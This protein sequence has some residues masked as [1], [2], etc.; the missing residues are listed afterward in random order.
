ML[1]PSLLSALR[2]AT[3]KSIEIDPTTIALIPTS[4]AKGQGGIV[5]TTVQPPREPQTFTIESIGA[6]LQGISGT[7][8]G[9]VKTE[10]G[11]AKSWSFNL[12]GRHDCVMEI[13][14]HWYEG[15]TGYRVISVQPSNGYEKR[16]V[17]AAFGSDPKYGA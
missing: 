7:G 3:I 2:K 11:Q 14:D 10:G 8:G 5:T 6:T 9:E 17:I 15:Q 13:G 16:G 12:V 4:R 1:K